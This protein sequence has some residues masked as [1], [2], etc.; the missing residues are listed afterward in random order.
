VTTYLLD[1]NVVVR[2]MEPSA[3][4]HVQVGNAVRSL[5]AAGNALVLAPQVLTELW[6]VATRPVEVNGFGWPPSKAADVIA[7]LR[8]QFPLLDDGPAAFE[9]WLALVA[10]A[11][12]RGK[13]AHDARLAAVMLSQDVTHI[14]TLNTADFDG[15]PGITAVHPFSI[16]AA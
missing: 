11:E 8:M 13:R 5:I 4:E 1:T 2:L 6:V 16:L 12:V 14:L 15:L 3:P 7:R 10:S 9:R